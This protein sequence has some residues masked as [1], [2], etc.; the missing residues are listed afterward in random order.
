MVEG[1]VDRITISGVKTYKYTEEHCD[2]MIG[3][4]RDD[5]DLYLFPVRFASLYKTS[6]SLKKIRMVR[7]NWDILLN[8]NDGYLSSLQNSLIT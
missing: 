7:N 8:W 5:L 3:V 6:V 2:L 4:S 1:G